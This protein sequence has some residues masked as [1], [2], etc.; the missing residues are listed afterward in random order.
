ME[1]WNGRNSSVDGCGSV[2]FELQGKDVVD[3]HL[4]YLHLLPVPDHL[5]EYGF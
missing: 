2:P 1:S 5:L 3:I 4:L